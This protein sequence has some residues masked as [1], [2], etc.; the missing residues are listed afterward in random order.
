MPH[1]REK[2][3]GASATRP[4]AWLRQAAIRYLIV[5]VVCL[6][7]AAPRTTP[8][9]KGRQETYRYPDVVGSVDLGRLDADCF[10]FFTWVN[11]G[12]FFVGLEHIQ[13]GSKDEFRK[14]GHSVLVFPDEIMVSIAFHTMACPNKPAPESSPAGIKNL[15]DSIS[16]EGSWKRGVELRSA[17]LLAPIELFQK[18]TKIKGLIAWA[19]TLRVRAKDVPLTDEFVISVFGPERRLLGRVKIDLRSDLKTPLYPVSKG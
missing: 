6:L 11:S 9:G 8:Q 1:E 13:R 14:N 2:R 15:L 12:D 5:A 18:P 10:G 17:E 3:K 16:L 4:S 7:V 19:Y